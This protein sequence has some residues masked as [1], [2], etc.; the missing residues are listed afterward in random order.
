[1][2]QVLQIASVVVFILYAAISEASTMRATDMDQAT[3]DKIFAGQLKDFYIEFRRGDVLPVSFSAEGDFFET[4]Q[5][6][7]TPLKVKRD[8]WVKVDGSKFEFSLDGT[9]FKPL[10][11]VARGFFSIGLTTA[12]DLSGGRVSGIQMNF[13][14][15]Q[16]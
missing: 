14:A 5:V 3:W 16:K 12:D 6:Q 1:M 9:T 7:P 11:D 8:L 4:Q 13:K 2:K 15:Y 10:S